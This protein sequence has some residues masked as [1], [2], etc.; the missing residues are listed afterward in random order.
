M[1][2]CDIETQYG[3]TSLYLARG[4]HLAAVVLH[5]GSGHIDMV[6]RTSILSGLLEDGAAHLNTLCPP[7]K[8]NVLN[9]NLERSHNDQNQIN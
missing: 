6:P 8:L 3:V 7:G 1:R 4:S 9:V 5:Q 2:L